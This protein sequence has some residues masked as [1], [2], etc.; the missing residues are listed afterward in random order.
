MYNMIIIGGISVKQTKNYRKGFTL[1][2]LLAVI[3]VLAI[4]LLI[5][6]PNVLGII[7]NAKDGAF[8]STAKIAA[9]TAKTQALPNEWLPNEKEC[10]VVRLSSLNLEDVDPTIDLD[11]SY[12]AIVKPTNVTEYW[13]ALKSSTKTIQLTNS[14]AELTVGT[15]ALSQPLSDPIGENDLST[16]ATKVFGGAGVGTCTAVPKT[17]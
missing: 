12:V 10:I 9:S 6:V 2:E 3:V 17:P 15:G 1:V 7:N 13:V 4:I 8:K 11:L 14:T 5:A 16:I